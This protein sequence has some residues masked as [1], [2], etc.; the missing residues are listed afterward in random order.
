MKKEVR[1]H[2]L[3]PTPVFDGHIDVK[4]EWLTYAKNG[5]YQ[6]MKSN[7]GAY[8]KN[9]YVLNELTDL[10]KDIKEQFD[11]YTRNYLKIKHNINFDFQN[12]WINKHIKGDSAHDHTHVNSIFSGVYYLHAG[13]GMGDISFKIQ[14]WWNTITPGYLLE[15]DEVNHVTGCEYTITPAPGFLTFFPSHLVHYVEPNNTD[16]E[17]YSL[18]FNLHFSKSKWGQMESEIEFR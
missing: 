14:P 8:T 7:N 18:A 9:F 10:K 3:F 5:D 17:R 6:R 4:P 2:E 13:P 15:Y 12:S 1:I 11:V 16:D